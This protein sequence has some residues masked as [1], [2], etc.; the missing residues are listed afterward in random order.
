MLVGKSVTVRGHDSV[1]AYFT[2]LH[3]QCIGKSGR[4]HA[5]VPSQPRDNPLIKVG[6]DE[7]TQIVFFRLHDLDVHSDAMPEHPRKHG[8][9]GSHLPG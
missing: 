7:G 2:D 6:F 8:K 4:V 3:R 9:R 5:V 1:P